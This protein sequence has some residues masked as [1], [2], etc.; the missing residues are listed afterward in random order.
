VDG[1]GLYGRQTLR[2]NLAYGG[3]PHEWLNVDD[4]EAHRPQSTP[5]T[6]DIAARLVRLLPKAAH[7]KVIRSWTGFIENTPD[8]R[9]IIDRLPMVGNAIVA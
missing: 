9:L 7:V 1:N 4:I 5:L 3:G 6:G 8:G 2:G